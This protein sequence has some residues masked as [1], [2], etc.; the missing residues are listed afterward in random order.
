MRPP[1]LLAPAGVAG[2]SLAFAAGLAPAGMLLQRQVQRA[3][4]GSISAGGW[5]GP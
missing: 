5:A 1:Q 4:D 2:A 3:R